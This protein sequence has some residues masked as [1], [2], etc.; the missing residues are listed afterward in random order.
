[1]D[2]D[3]AFEKFRECAVEVLQVLPLGP[4]NCRLRAFDYAPAAGGRRERALAYLAGC[5]AQR[6][7]VADAALATSIQKGLE[8]PG[9]VGEPVTRAPA[10]LTEF[11][12]IIARLLP[13]AL[14]HPGD[15]L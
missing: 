3:A 11:R 7:L 9:P 15:P 2:S 13:A 6:R 8:S 12:N 4:G 5:L 14:R 10:P 1:M